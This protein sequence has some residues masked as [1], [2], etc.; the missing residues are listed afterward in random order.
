LETVYSFDPSAAATE[1]SDTANVATAST[2]QLL[3]GGQGNI[4]TERM[5]NGSEVEYMTYPRACALAEVLWTAGNALV[6]Q[7]FKA[8]LQVHLRRLDRLHVNYR[9]D[10][11]RAAHTPPVWFE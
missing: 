10:D 6:Y 3:L 9:C 11:G 5:A 2:D 1:Q 8:R 4:W 7:S